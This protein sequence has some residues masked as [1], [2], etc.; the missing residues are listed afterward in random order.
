MVEDVPEM[1][2]LL[3]AAGLRPG[4]TLEVVERAPH[5]NEVIVKGPTGRAAIPID[6]ARL[7]AVAAE[8]DSALSA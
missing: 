3:A 7:V 1:L 6:L 8:A 2:R 5:G 4:A